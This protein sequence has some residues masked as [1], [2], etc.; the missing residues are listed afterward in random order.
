M[1][2]NMKNGLPAVFE[3][4]DDKIFKIL[5]LETRD[6]TAYASENV[7]AAA[8]N[9][10]IA[11]DAVIEDF[12]SVKRLKNTVFSGQEIQAGWCFG[13]R[14]QM[15]AL[16][17]HES[18]EVVVAC[19]DLV[20]LLGRK[21]DV[22]NGKYDSGKLKTLFLK[23]GTAVELF[24]GTLHFAPLPVGKR[25]VAVIILPLGTNLP[26]PENEQK[27]MKTAKNKW[28][29][30]HPEGRAVITARTEGAITGENYLVT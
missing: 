1:T 14:R 28:L 8:E 25:F 30:V 26:L 10:Y 19:T 2:E 6:I 7:Q 13:G 4:T 22:Q 17:W 15:T 24:A 20:L 23:A 11:S 18:S 16:E 12:T 5:T 3:Q 9:K 29:L 27:E 21:E